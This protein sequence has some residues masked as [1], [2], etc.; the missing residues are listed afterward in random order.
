MPPN[1]P[2]N[3]IA[4][5]TRLRVNGTL[6]AQEEI[7]VKAWI[8]NEAALLI[9]WVILLVLVLPRLF[10]TDSGFVQYIFWTLML[11]SLPL[12]IRYIRGKKIQARKAPYQEKELGIWGYFWRS[13][14]SLWVVV[15]L[16]GLGSY[17]IAG[18]VFRV[19]SF[20]GQVLFLAAVPLVVWLIFCKERIA[21]ARKKFLYFS[22]MPV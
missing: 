20:F 15:L 3:P 5:K 2:L 12:S 4:A 21:F 1:N 9:A 19:D 13:W 8:R 10:M 7:T 6:C 18:T 22:G 17:L 11:F 16:V 14:V